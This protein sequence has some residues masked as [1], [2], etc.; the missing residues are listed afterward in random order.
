M[1]SRRPRTKS[2]G[3]VPLRNLSLN[4]SSKKPS[5][6][7]I[8]PDRSSRVPTDP[9]SRSALK[10]AHSSS[11]IE[12]SS[13]RRAID[14]DGARS[15]K[16]SKPSE[17][18]DNTMLMNFGLISSMMSKDNPSPRTEIE[19]HP[20]LEDFPMRMSATSSEPEWYQ[21]ILTALPE[22]SP[23]FIGPKRQLESAEINLS[24]RKHRY[25]TDGLKFYN[26]MMQDFDF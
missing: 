1:T 25:Y 26:M 22:T 16:T 8:K 18:W 12:K 14:S 24:F 15:R 11:T 9:R 20:D 10:R 7:F 2:P 4:T 5:G 17:K 13:K 6:V 21:R 23:Y 3:A 19:D